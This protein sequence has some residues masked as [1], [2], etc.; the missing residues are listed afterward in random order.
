MGTLLLILINFLPVPSSI[1]GPLQRS[2]KVLLNFPGSTDD[3]NPPASTGETG[4]IP[5]L[6]R[7]HMLRGNL[8]HVPQLLSLCAVTAEAG[9]PRA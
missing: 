6:G 5:G 1:P 8:R 4:S 7:L 9:L 2:K 3:K